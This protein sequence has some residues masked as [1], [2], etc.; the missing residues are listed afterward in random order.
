MSE[1]APTIEEPPKKMSI[2]QRK[3]LRLKTLP[4][5][6]AYG[7]NPAREH[8]RETEMVMRAVC[9]FVHKKGFCPNTN[10][11]SRAHT[12]QKEPLKK[13]LEELHEGGYLELHCEC[14]WK[15]TRKAFERI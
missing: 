8:E 1:E 14:V 3:R 13:Y 7:L 10:A 2:A 4:K 15:P 11:L 9:K 12:W 6:R 5:T